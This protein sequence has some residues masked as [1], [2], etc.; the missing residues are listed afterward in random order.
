[1]DV[2]LV[3]LRWLTGGLQG[4]LIGRATFEGG[5]SG[6]DHLCVVKTCILVRRDRQNGQVD[7]A[8]ASTQDVTRVH[9]KSQRG[10]TDLLQVRQV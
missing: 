9:H 2:A 10:V 3:E 6:A 4:R 1:M 7:V 5:P 8:Y